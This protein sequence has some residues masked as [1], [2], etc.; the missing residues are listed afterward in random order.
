MTLQAALAA[1]LSPTVTPHQS[2]RVPPV[3]T[4][5]HHTGQLTHGIMGGLHSVGYN[6]FYKVMRLEKGSSVAVRNNQEVLIGEGQGHAMMAVH[7]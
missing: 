1:P 7:C 3:H 5:S 4:H 2:T 6:V